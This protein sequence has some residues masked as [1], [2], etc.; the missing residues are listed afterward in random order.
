MQAVAA[1]T[2]DPETCFRAFIDVATFP[3]WIPGLRRAQ[4]VQ[5]DAAGL[6]SE[7]VFEFGAS[8]T[9]SLAYRYDLANREVTW[10]PRSNKRDAVVGFAKFETIDEGTR[11]TYG[12]APHTGEVSPAEIDALLTAFIAYLARRG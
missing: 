5:S 4:V 7:I 1:V 3:A 10:E 8:R 9:Y 11:I 6:A 12:N 2:R